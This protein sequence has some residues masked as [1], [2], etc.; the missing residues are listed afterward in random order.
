MLARTQ[1]S[2]DVIGT[3]LNSLVSRYAKITSTGFDKITSDDDGEA[4]SFNDV[5]KALKKVGIEMYDIVDKTFMPMNE[6]LDQL[7][8]R[9]YGLDEATQKYIATTMAGTRGM[10]Y[11]L[12]L[13]QNY[14]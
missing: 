3:Q 8:E 14:D 6:V 9:W 7:G 1:Q 4:L 13:M 12:T 5:S 11:F 2:G 10:N